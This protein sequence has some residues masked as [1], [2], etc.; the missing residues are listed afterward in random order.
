MLWISL[1]SATLILLKDLH[2]VDQVLKLTQN[3]LML[4]LSEVYDLLARQF[5]MTFR[6]Y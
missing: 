2:S 5:K 1:R 4:A 6:K 3:F